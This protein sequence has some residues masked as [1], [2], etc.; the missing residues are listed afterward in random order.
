MQCLCWIFD[1]RHTETNK[2]KDIIQRERTVLT[3]ACDIDQ[4][5]KKMFALSSSHLCACEPCV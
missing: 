5:K 2:C 1:E 4:T 3:L